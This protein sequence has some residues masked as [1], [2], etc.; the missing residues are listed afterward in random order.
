MWREVVIRQCLPIRKTEN[1]QR[2]SSI[3]QFTAKV[4]KF[5]LK[6]LNRFVVLADQQQRPFA[7][8]SRIGQREASCAA[9]SLLP[10]TGKI[11]YLA[12]AEGYK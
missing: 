1:L 6:L 7:I 11:A 4:A 10:V 5:S 12:A 3:R 9:E 2:V 8:R